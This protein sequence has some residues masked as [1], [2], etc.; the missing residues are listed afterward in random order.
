MA[1]MTRSAL[2]QFSGRLGAVE[3]AI[4]G[5]RSIVKQA[6]SKPIRVTPARA[7]A[8]NVQAAAIAHW[9]G[10][11]DAQRLAWNKA[12]MSHPSYD[13]LGT[14]RFPN[15]F[16]L[17]LSIP[18]DFTYTEFWDWMDT[19][20]TRQTERDDGLT[21]LAAADANFYV[22]NNLWYVQSDAIIWIYVARFRP[23]NSKRRAY[24][25]K[26]FGPLDCLTGSVDFM[27]CIAAENVAY[28]EGETIAV[29][30]G[31]C[32]PLRWPIVQNIGTTVIVAP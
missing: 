25:W 14:Y 22:T 12:A 23:A 7:H 19:P 5:G 24:T 32:S 18:H 2:G 6:K 16:Q 21:V 17:F 13:R 3:F 11:T 26:R 31:S 8:Q 30:A 29:R 20:P 1:L 10:L 9:H 27:N 28:I 15:G 4:H